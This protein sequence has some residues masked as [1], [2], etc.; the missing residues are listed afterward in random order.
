MTE[1]R[2]FLSLGSNLGDRLGYL[3]SA[4]TALRN[5]PNIEIVGASSVYE[6]VAMYM[7]ENTPP[8]L[9]AAVEIQTSLDPENLLDVLQ[10][11]ESELGRPHGPRARYESRVIDIDIAL[12]GDRRISSSRLIVP[13]PGLKNRRFFLQPLADLDPALPLPDTELTVSERAAELAHNQLLTAVGPA[14]LPV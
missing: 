2:V 3:R 9:N 6:S 5:E 7:D 14:S 4:V 11:I 13:H 10:R 1:E 12:W 8:F